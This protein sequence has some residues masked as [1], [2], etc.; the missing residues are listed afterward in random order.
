MKTLALIQTSRDRFFE[1]Q[2]FIKSLNSQIDIIFNEIQYIFIDQGNN[3]SAFKDLNP[4]IEFK[5]I[6]IEPCSLSHA[7]NIGITNCNAKYISFPDDD[8]WYE[9]NTLS[10]VLNILEKNEY[11]GLTIKATNENNIP[12]GKFPNHSQKISLYNHCGAC[13]ITIFFQF[14]KELLF[15]ENLGVGSPHKFSAGEESDYI[16]N[17]IKKYNG[18]VFYDSTICIHHP[19][20][21]ANTFTDYHLKKYYYGR[22]LGYLYRKHNYPF[23]VIFISLIK[24]L[25]G[26]IVYMAIGNFKKSKQSFYF[27]KGKLEGFL[28]SKKLLHN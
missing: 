14:K 15:D 21:K 1:L 8:C 24:P 19:I 9:P 12:I 20:G 13:S 17:F 6:K 26:S 2:T 25:I 7:R 4:R 3:K 28:D 27:A 11:S 16:I 22:G 10:C 18:N 5:Y 23:S